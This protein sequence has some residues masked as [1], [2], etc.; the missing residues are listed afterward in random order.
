MESGHQLEAAMNDN[1]RSV[2]DR[3][4][5]DIGMVIAQTLSAVLRRHVSPDDK[6]MREN[7]P[8]WDS[9]GHAEI[10]L[11]LED[12]FGITFD[13]SEIIEISDSEALKALIERKYAS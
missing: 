2:N 7:E 6:V 3:S 8:K 11:T 1:G 13:E 9:L 10:I 4:M 12:A 5:N